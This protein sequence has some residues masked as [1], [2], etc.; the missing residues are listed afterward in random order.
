MSDQTDK[1]DAKDAKAEAKQE[2]KDAKEHPRGTEV[3]GAMAESE[4]NQDKDLAERGIYQPFDKVTNRP[5]PGGYGTY[6][7]EESEELAEHRKNLAH[8]TPVPSESAG[9]ASQAK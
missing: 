7:E 8:L 3:R 6:G 9:A 5:G 2:A 1:Q 4:A